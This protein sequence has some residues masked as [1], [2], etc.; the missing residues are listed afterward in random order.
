MNAFHL[1][2]H[3]S[4]LLSLCLNTFPPSLVWR[5]SGCLPHGVRSDPS[6]QLKHDSNT[7]LISNMTGL[8]QRPIGLG[9]SL[10]RSRVQSAHLA[11]DGPPRPPVPLASAP[12]RSLGCWSWDRFTSCSPS[13][14]PD[15]RHVSSSEAPVFFF[16][17][18]ACLI[19]SFL[20][21]R[22]LKK[23]KLFWCRNGKST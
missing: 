16:Y 12:C 13:P 6:S 14:C 7:H 10:H 20:R 15:Y 23:K 3:V 22:L 1:Q 21:T 19:A 11:L 5:V 8:G 17:S 2:A 18:L 9:H 4:C